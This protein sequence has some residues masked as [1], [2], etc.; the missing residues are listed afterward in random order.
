MEIRRTKR[1]DCPQRGGCTNTTYF[2]S[3]SYRVIYLPAC[4]H[5]KVTVDP[6]LKSRYNAD[7][8]LI[9]IS[10]SSSQR[11]LFVM[12]GRRKAFVTKQPG[13]ALWTVAAAIVTALR[14]PFWLVRFIPSRF[15]QHP[16]WTYHQAIMNELIRKFL[17]HSTYVEMYTPI[18]LDEKD[19]FVKINPSPNHI[20]HGLLDHPEVQPTVT[21]GTWYP[22]PY[23]RGDEQIVVLHFHGG[24]YVTSE[25]RT[26]DIDFAAKTLAGN[27]NAKILFPSY[28][29]ASNERCHFPAAL[30]DAVSAYQYLL[31]LGISPSRIAVSGD[32]AGASLAVS[33]LRYIGGSGGKLPDP[34]A[35]LLFSP[36][37]DIN[38]AHNQENI[39]SNRNYKT[40]Y[41]PG[42]FT[43]WGART[44]IPEHMDVNNPYF[45]PLDHAFL[46]TT[47]LWIQVGGVEILYDEG[48]K[49][50]DAMKKK[51]NKVDVYVEPL[52]NHDILLVGQLSGFAAEAQRAVKLA[53]EFLNANRKA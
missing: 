10:I 53:G 5:D 46:T 23:K 24:A 11:T 22:S 32:S 49:F 30:Q 35:A 39:N 13:K 34:S 8:T 4:C 7:D 14:L 52:A 43:A 16:Q 6:C 31:D 1:K 20:Y 21:G 41:L 19:G 2:P 27:L 37:L 12:A 17:Y 33:L 26:P 25:G 40:D 9:L 47:P 51:G 48:V 44:Y 50:A 15:R 29:L 45:S 18:R 38:S 42:N 36:W 28:R 3:F